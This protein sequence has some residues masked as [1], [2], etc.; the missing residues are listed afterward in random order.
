[1]KKLDFKK[2]RSWYPI[3]KRMVY[4]NNGSISPMS[5]RVLGAVNEFLG[6]VRD[7]GRIHYPKWCKFA[8]Q[9]IKADIGRLIGAD[10][11]E[12][13]FVKNTTEGLNIVANGIDWRKGDNAVIADIEYPSNVY[14]WMNL[15]RRGVKIK[16]VPTREGRILVDDIAATMDKR[17]R[18]V[19]LSGVQF[20]NGFRLDLERLSHLCHKRKVFLNLDMI[21]WL[22]ALQIDLSQWPI[23]FLSAGGHKWLLSPIGTGIFFCRQSALDKLQLSTVGYHTVDKSEDHLDYDLTPRPNASRF[24]EALVNFPGLW[25][26][27]A[28]IK[29]FLELG[30]DNVEKHVLGLADHAIEG[31]QSRG[32][33]V[34]SSTL[35]GERSGNVCFQ[36]PNLAPEAIEQR[37]I[38]AKVRA[39]VRPGG[40]RI[41]ASIYNDTADIDALLDALPQI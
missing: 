18:V 17:T 31:L 8:E 23:D 7:N 6:D 39:A 16:W 38:E 35:A 33:R 19:S 26:L 32:Y 29:T 10:R 15:K 28:A 4:L 2:V 30:M 40:I 24:E 25:G 20:S 9:N 12:I 41:S 14:C 36:H 22:G 3:R 11:K 27:H 13:A 21:H 1:M 5:T 37:L 34:T